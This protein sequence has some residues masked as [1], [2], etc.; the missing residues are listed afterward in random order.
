MLITSLIKNI[1]K[2]VIVWLVIFGFFWLSSNIYHV[3]AQEEPSITVSP[4]TQQVTKQDAIVDLSVTLDVILNFLYV[5]LWPMLAITGMALDNTL[6]YGSVF[7]LDQIL[8]QIWTVV[9]YLSFVFLWVMILRDIAKAAI[10]GGDIQTIIKKWVPNW[11]IAGIL[12]PMSWFLM[13]VVIDLSTIAIYQVWNIPLTIMQTNSNLDQK[14]LEIHSTIDLNSA[15]KPS[16]QGWFRYSTYYSCQQENFIPCRIENYKI[17][18]WLQEDYI[19]QF[20]IGNKMTSW[21]ISTEYCVM[22]PTQLYKL[23]YQWNGTWSY[24]TITWTAF[25]KWIQDGQIKMNSCNSVKNIIESSQTMVWPLYTIYWSLLNFASINNT[26]S[27]KS[28]EAEAVIFLIKTIVGL[29][30][31]IPL[32]WLAVM[33][34]WRVGMLWLAIAFSPIIIMFKLFKWSNDTLWKI[35]WSMNFKWWIDAK[36]DLKNII[37]LIFQPVL[38]VFALGLSLILLTATTSMLTPSTSDQNPS[39]TSQLL[40]SFNMETRIDEKNNTQCLDVEWYVTTCVTDFPSKFSSTVFADYFSWIIANIIGI[41]VMRN[42]LFASMKWNGITDNMV[43][44]VEKVGN[45]FL[46]NN[47]PIFWWYS[48]DSVFGDEGISKV[49]GAITDKFTEDK[50]ADRAQVLKKRIESRT[51]G[52][53]NKMDNDIKFETPIWPDN[54]PITDQSIIKAEASSSFANK[55]WKLDTSKGVYLSE[56]DLSNLKSYKNIWGYT[57][58]NLAEYLGDKKFWEFMNTTPE[59]NGLLNDWL[60]IKDKKDVSKLVWEKNIETFMTNIHNQWNLLELKSGEKDGHKVAAKVT[61]ESWWS[62]VVLYYADIGT[63]DGKEIYEKIN[64]TNI[65]KKNIST[66]NSFIES[67]PHMW[68]DTKKIYQDELGYNIDET[69]KKI[70]LVNTINNQSN[71]PPRPT[72]QNW[73]NTDPA[74]QV[75]DSMLDIDLDDDSE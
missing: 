45:N 23:N 51:D 19:D 1:K 37:S 66:I 53:F 40:K 64:T 11:I 33:S 29:L 5:I 59:W 55:V 32:I 69:N 62:R 60:N 3:Q 14:L 68:D 17:T 52:T 48:Y 71:N 41:L 42:L 20:I 26:D 9:M 75:D 58:N 38:T 74:E 36:F 13:W 44:A 56:D 27:W 2:T 15:I 65:D 24:T 67:Y 46:K 22:T 8:R 6:V 16:E 43:W 39:T 61:P 63:K 50:T 7:H 73:N 18:K 10:Q 30:L 28:V 54:K 21:S 57:G 47:I 35:Q 12:I 4:E 25:T 34:I 70:K 31:I 49:F 72:N